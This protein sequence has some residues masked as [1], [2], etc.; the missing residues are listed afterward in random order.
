MFK[1]TVEIHAINA[2]AKVAI[3]GTRTGS[4]VPVVKTLLMMEI[5]KHILIK[6]TP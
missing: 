6:L 2:S 1:E 5:M 3:A 4:M